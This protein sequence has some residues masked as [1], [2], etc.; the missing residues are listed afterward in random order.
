MEELKVLVTGGAGFIGSNI[1]EELLKMGVKKVRVLDNLSTGK[2]SNINNLAKWWNATKVGSAPTSWPMTIIVSK[3][4]GAIAINISIKVNSVEFEIT[5][6][7]I[8][9]MS[10]LNAVKRLPI[11]TYDLNVLRL[12][13]V[14]RD[15]IKE[16]SMMKADVAK[17]SGTTP[18]VKLV[19]WPTVEQNIPPKRKAAGVL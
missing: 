3:P 8:I 19:P 15:P 18:G 6:A 7:V 14:K 17:Y 2:K 1:V 16:P 10:K 13:P 12:I 11:K 5:K 9:A 4:P